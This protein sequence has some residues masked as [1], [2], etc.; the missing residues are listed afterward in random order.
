MGVASP[1]AGGEPRTLVV[2]GDSLSAAYGFDR[3]AG[4]V[5][6][7]ADRIEEQEFPWRVV[8]S[9]VSGDRTH[10][11]L[12]R[13]PRVLERHEPALVLIALGGNDGLRGRNPTEIKGNLERLVAKARDAGACVVLAGV[14]I[15]PNYGRTYTERFEAAYR[16][17]AQTHDVP[18]IP[19]LLADVAER[20]EMMQEDGIHPTAEAQGQILDNVWAV[21][22]D[23][24]QSEACASPDRP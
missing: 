1:V 21:L 8:N 6:L 16:D 17:V 20:R 11:G 3:E 10:E 4:W 5:A 22:A 7:L 15:P 9:S 24:L 13:L 18:L 2:L 14:R 19:K 12:R 23:A